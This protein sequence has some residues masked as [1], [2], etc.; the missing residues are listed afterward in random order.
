MNPQLMM[1]VEKCNKEEGSI[2]ENL[3]KDWFKTSDNFGDDESISEYCA[4]D[5]C[6][7]FNEEYLSKQNLSKEEYFKIVY[8]IL[9]HFEVHGASQ[10]CEWEDWFCMTNINFGSTI[11]DSVRRPDFDCADNE[12][13]TT[14]GEEGRSIYKLQ[15]T[16]QEMDDIR[17][18][19]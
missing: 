9:T 7:D 4:L 14:S 13:T 16:E 3:F 11:A 1:T 12:Y 17:H 5:L 18:I 19:H 6:Y 2:Y 15:Y 8:H 10:G